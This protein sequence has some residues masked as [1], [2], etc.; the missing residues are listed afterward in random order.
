[1]RAIL[2]AA[3]L[4]TRLEPLTSILPKCLMPVRGTPLLGRWLELLDEVGVDEFLIN[5]HHLASSVARFVAGT[6]FASRVTLVHEPELLGTGETVRRNLAFLRDQDGFILHADNSLDG[7]LEG[8]LA[9]HRARPE[10]CVATVMTFDADDL[11]TC[12]VATTDAHGVVLEYRHKP[13]NPVPGR[14]NAATY[15]IGAGFADTVSDLWPVSDFSAEIIPQLVG[16]LYSHHHEGAYFDIGLPRGFLL[17]NLP[18]AH[19]GL[20]P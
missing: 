7:D 17:A 13:T 1:M 8:L 2:L 19:R 11:R 9:S 10:G 3:G 4:G 15:V 5:T 20:V 12:G 18:A 14:A 6:R 16:R